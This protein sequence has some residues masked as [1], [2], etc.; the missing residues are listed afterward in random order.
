LTTAALAALCLWQTR[1]F[2]QQTPPPD[3]GSQTSSKPDKPDGIDILPSPDEP[4]SVRTT[5]PPPEIRIPNF[6]SCS[7]AELRKAIPDLGHLKAAQ[8]QS[9]LPALLD[10]IGTK[11]VDI[12]SRTPNLVSDESVVSDH[13]GIETVQNFSFLVLQHISKSGAI[14]LDEFRVDARSGE[15][16]Q[17][18]ALE[19]AIEAR[20][21]SSES[22][23]LGLPSR[24]SLPGSEKSPPAQGFV[25]E[26]LN[27]YP[28]NRSHADFRYLGQQKVKGRPMLVVAFSQK[29]AVIPI[30]AMLAYENRLYKIFLQGVA[31]VD[32]KD[33]RIVRLRTDILSAPPGVPLRQFSADTHFTE[34]RVAEIATPLWLP[35][36]VV[37]TSNFAASTLRETHSY[38]HYRLFRTKSKLL[39][40]P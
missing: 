38:S 6:T 9:Q 34:I 40:N 24:R 15:K 7:I 1:A 16:F 36:Q 2:A 11:T 28:P 30:P 32:A 5:P 25:N 21:H 19:K 12:A 18:E 10:K 27:F 13:L 20:A 39:L 3:S 37:I 31:W 35:R 33:F 14:I 4:S 26:W 17:T 23:S 22:S 8:D 29:P